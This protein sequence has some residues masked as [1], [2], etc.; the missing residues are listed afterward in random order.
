MTVTMPIDRIT[1]KALPE[2]VF[3]SPTDIVTD[4]RLTSGEKLGTLRRWADQINA[5][6]S[7]SSEGMPTNGTTTP[8]HL[9]LDHITAAIEIGRAH[10]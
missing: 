9:L 1:A 3:A 6:L 4:N 5:Q 10:V 8:D 7:A 2:S